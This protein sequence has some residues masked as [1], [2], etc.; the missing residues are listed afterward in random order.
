MATPGAKR[1]RLVEKSLPP[2]IETY[3]PESR[4]F[5]QLQALERKLDTK[6][7]RKRLEVQE[8]LGKPVYRKR[9][10]RI[11]VSNLAANQGAAGAGGGANDDTDAEGGD[12]PVSGTMEAPSWTLRIEGRLVDQPGATS[13]ARPAAHKF[14]EFISSMVVELERDPELYSDNVVQ[15]RRGAAEGDVDGFEIKRR[16]DEDVRAKILLDIR[17]ATDRFKVNSPLL[18]ELLDIRGSISKAG[19]IMKLWQYIKFNNLQDSDD[20]DQIRCDSGLAQ[21]LG[22]SVVSF[23]ALPQMLHVFL[24]RPDPLVVEYTVRVH[25]GDFH[26]GQYAFDV[27]VEV[28][29]PS[30]QGAGPLAN[31]QSRHHELAHV[32]TQL[33]HRMQEIHNARAKRDFLRS[34]ANDPVAFVHRWIDNQTKDLEV[35]LGDRRHGLEAALGAIMAAD[36][37]AQ[38]LSAGRR[39]ALEHE[40]ARWLKESALYDEPWADEAVF[41]YLSAKTQERMQQLL[42]QQQQPAAAPAAPGHHL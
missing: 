5:M 21:A 26:M 37:T 22:S 25:E 42:Q 39:Q 28:E 23:T 13:K 41:H 40:A 33:G 4:L 36:S 34:F 29:E 11:F 38:E 31:L 10:L 14:S 30:R 1:K 6:I 32:E 12:A 24:T 35:V 9:I 17:T 27:E 7:V 3:I 20:P 2:R 15:W 8:A 16:G 18:R 19:F